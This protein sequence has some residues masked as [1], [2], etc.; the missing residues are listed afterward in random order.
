MGVP[1][2]HVSILRNVIVACLCHLFFTMSQV[3]FKKN[4]CRMS[5]GPTSPCGIQKN[6]LWNL[7]GQ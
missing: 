2:C 3:E 1:Q 4:L 6:G 7:G 5:L